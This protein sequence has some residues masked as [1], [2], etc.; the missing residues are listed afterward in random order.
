MFG[1]DSS[2]RFFFQSADTDRQSE[3]RL[4]VLPTH[5]NARIPRHRHPRDDPREDVGVGVVE[6]GLN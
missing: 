3:T 1:V 2:S 6:C 5:D 4:I